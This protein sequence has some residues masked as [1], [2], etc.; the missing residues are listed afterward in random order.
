MVGTC[1]N[2]YEK[3]MDMEIMWIWIHCLQY[4][5]SAN[6]TPNTNVPTPFYFIGRMYNSMLDAKGSQQV[7]LKSSQ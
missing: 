5:I 1:G 4:T 6:S 2:S 3:Q 7:S